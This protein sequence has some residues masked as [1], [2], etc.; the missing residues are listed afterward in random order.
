MEINEREY[1]ENLLKEYPKRDYILKKFDLDIEQIKLEDYDGLKALTYD[2]DKIQTSG[3][4]DIVS[5][6][7]TQREKAIERVEKEKANKILHFDK[8]ENALIFLNELQYKIIEYRYF[9]QYTWGMCEKRIGYTDRQCQNI[10]KEILNN[11]YSY[12]NIRPLKEDK[13]LN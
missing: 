11:L 8:I 5:R 7:V 12:Y 4:S 2:S 10:A 1:I 9:K 3:T 6:L 13:S